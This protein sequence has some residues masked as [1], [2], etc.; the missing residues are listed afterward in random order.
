MNSVIN[1]EKDGV[2]FTF[3]TFMQLVL[4]EEDPCEYFFPLSIPTVSLTLVSVK[5]I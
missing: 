1:L 5:S 3:F 4:C 2:C